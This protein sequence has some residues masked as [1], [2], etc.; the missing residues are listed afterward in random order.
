MGCL[1]DPLCRA[2]SS[3]PSHHIIPHCVWGCC[4]IV[5]STITLL[6]K[7]V[8]EDT[9]EESGG[10]LR[11]FPNPPQLSTNSVTGPVPTYQWPSV[12]SYWTLLKYVKLLS[13]P[14]FDEPAFC[15]SWS[16]P[17]LGRGIHFPPEGRGQRSKSS[18]LLSWATYGNIKVHLI[19]KYSEIIL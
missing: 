11:P 14:A 2:A 18:V 10:W 19:K 5:Q 3:C 17:V 4:V 6:W 7:S 1:F 15:F 8:S 16:R 12:H 9:K 13:V